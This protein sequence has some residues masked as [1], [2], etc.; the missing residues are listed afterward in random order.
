MKCH[1]LI[2]GHTG[3]VG[4]ALISA[5]QGNV[6]YE[7]SG[8]SRANGKDLLASHVLEQ[9][10]KADKIIHLAALVGVLQ[11]WER[12]REVYQTNIIST[13]NVLEFARLQRIPVIYL[14]SYIY[15]SPQYLPIDESHPINCGNPYAVS[16]LQ[17]EMLCEN[18][19]K[20]F[21]VP[22]TILRPFNLYGPGQTR[23]SL[24][25]SIIW[26]AKEK[27]S[28]QVKDLRP[29][30]DY[31]Y[32]A[33]MV[34]ALVKVIRSEQRGLEIYN[35]GFGKSYSVKE[36]IDTVSK[37]M[38]K[39]LPVHSTEEYRR[40]EIMDCYSDSK[41]FS[42]RLGWR[43]KVDLEEGIK[44]LLNSHECTPIQS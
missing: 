7:I 42:E 28:I 36:V 2:T 39:H 26:Q 44:R 33:D 38:G 16:K 3:F 32:I 15:G 40:N 31:L 8:A 34:D 11:G 14:S 25:P 10:P 4:S 12:P 35:V 37:L 23:E 21:G 13:L 43:Q 20:H 41:K 27:N 30:R 6:D 18:Y 29:K 17:A 1:L 19:A 22:V 5:L 24:I 9:L